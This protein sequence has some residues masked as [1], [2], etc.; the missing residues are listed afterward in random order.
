MNTKT[1]VQKPE[2]DT[3]RK[4]KETHQNKIG[5]RKTSFS[6]AVCDFLCIFAGEIRKNRKWQNRYLNIIN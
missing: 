3:N 1:S 5:I 2:D 6:L 4:L